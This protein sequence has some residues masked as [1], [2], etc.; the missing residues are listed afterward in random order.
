MIRES[1]LKESRNYCLKPNMCFPPC[2]LNGK[3]NRK[4]SE[5]KCIFY[6][7]NHNIVIWVYGQ[8]E[9]QEDR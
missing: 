2:Q 1:E 8:A 9:R 7:I 3:T 4:Q 5:K 6:K